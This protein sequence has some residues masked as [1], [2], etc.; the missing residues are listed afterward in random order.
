MGWVGSIICILSFELMKETFG[1]LAIFWVIAGLNA[2][3]AALVFFLPYETKGKML[4]DEGETE[5][6]LGK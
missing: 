5:P 1:T 6:L 2:V 3:N 4:D